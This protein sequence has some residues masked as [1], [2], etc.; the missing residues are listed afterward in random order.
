MEYPVK[1]QEDR[2]VDGLGQRSVLGVYRKLVWPTLAGEGKSGGRERRKK[3]E[4][5]NLKQL[6]EYFLMSSGTDN[7]E[8]LRW[9]CNSF[10]MMQCIE[11]GREGGK[12]KRKKNQSI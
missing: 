6:V 3:P 2:K 12:G 5:R 4:L 7:S 9:L 11:R 8:K 10:V 1:G